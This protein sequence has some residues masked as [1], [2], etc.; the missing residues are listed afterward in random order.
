MEKAGGGT[1]QLLS[2]WTRKRLNSHYTSPVLT[3]P[4]FLPGATYPEM[5][6]RLLK[7]LLYHML[8][9]FSVFYSNVILSTNLQP[10]FF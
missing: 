6:L 5:S 10:A 2:P 7:G 4:V 3:E 8:K 1:F 9:M